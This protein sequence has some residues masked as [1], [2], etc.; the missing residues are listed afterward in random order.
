M[1]SGVLKFEN[2]GSIPSGQRIVIY[3][4]DTSRAGASSVD[5][6]RTTVTIPEDFD[7]SA[8]DLPFDL[9]FDGSAEGLTLRAHMPMH[10]GDDVRQGDMVTTV[11]TPATGANPVS[12]TLRRV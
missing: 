8:D 6:A 4:R 10:D 12:L 5:R 1:I 2:P 3:L 9:A 7:A 11:S